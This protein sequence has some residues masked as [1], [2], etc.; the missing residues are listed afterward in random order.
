ME[1]TTKEIFEI[2]KD[3]HCDECKPLELN[4]IKIWVDQFAAADRK[5]L[6]EE[7]LHILKQDIYVSKEKALEL[8]WKNFEF[9]ANNLGYNGDLRM[10]V[11]ESH[12]FNVQ[13]EGKSQT[14][15]FSMLDGLVEN[16]LGI[17]L[18]ADSG[19]EIK[20]FIY[21]DDVVA[22]GKTLL[23]TLRDWLS[24]DDN[25]SLVV[26]GQKKLIVSV[27]CMHQWALDNLRWSLKCSFENDAFLKLPFVRY[28]YLIDNRVLY[29]SAKLN[30]VLPIKE[31]SK[32]VLDYFDT[33]E[34]DSN[35]DKAFRKNE[36]PTK[37]TF[38]SSSENRNRFEAIILEKGVEI[39]NKVVVKKA[40]NRPLG[41]TYPHYKTLGTGTLFF[42]WRNISNTCPLVFWWDNPAHEWK[43]LFTL[44][45]RG[46]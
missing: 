22:T 4:D 2:I 40:S 41:A 35:K 32:T 27:F 43:S 31:Q 17:R 36:R 29:P 23:G 45:G 15:L 10:F 20:N 7:F 11:F 37:E 44:K 38:F 18:N 6:L 28:N 13:K 26:S 16:K 8:L 9:I 25:A 21:I 12:F 3:Y 46:N 30:L 24:K 39:L 42:T 19:Y 33:I 34:A 5:F 14:V 1:A